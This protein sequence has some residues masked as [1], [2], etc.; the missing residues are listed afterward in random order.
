MHL[1]VNKLTNEIEHKSRKTSQVYRH[2]FITK[3]T[4]Q[5]TGFKKLLR[6]NWGSTIYKIA[7]SDEIQIKL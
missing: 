7:T 2:L 6:V 4:L 1:R 5:D 3:L